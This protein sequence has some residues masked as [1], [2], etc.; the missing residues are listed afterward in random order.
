MKLKDL[1]KDIEVITLA[2]D[3]ELEISDLT[4]DS[5]KATPGSLFVAVTGFV[6]DG[7]LY[8]PMALEKGAVAV[9]TAVKPK[10]DIPYILVPSDRLALALLA[11]RFYDYPARSMTL[12][13][14][15]GTNGKTSSTLLL[16]H[17]L[18]VVKGAK[19]GLMGTMENIIGDEHIPADRGDVT[20]KGY[21][22]LFVPGS[23]EVIGNAPEGVVIACY[24]DHIGGAEELREKYGV[25]ILIGEKDNAALSDPV[26]NESV[27]FRVHINPFTADKTVALN[28][29]SLL[30]CSCRGN[31]RNPSRRTSTAN[32]GIV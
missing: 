12:I 10:E 18:E 13:G 14:V 6:T 15:T 27:R 17:V 31:R 4:Y 22:N 28:K 24:F 16:K 25:N 3:P 5:R 30:P 26:V 1:L 32:N 2:A 9:V 23:G 19:V 29:C 8:I 11:A 21:F 20:L 7:N